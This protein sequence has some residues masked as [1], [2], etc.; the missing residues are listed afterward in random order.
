MQ[1]GKTKA[2]FWSTSQIPYIGKKFGF[3]SSPA[4]QQVITFF[5]SKGGILKTTMAHETARILALN[6]IIEHFKINSIR[7]STICHQYRTE[8]NRIE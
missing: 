5:T 6:G 7:I 4:K 2:R 3:L 8:W 1:R